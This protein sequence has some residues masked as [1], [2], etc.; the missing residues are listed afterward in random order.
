MGDHRASRNAWRVWAAAAG[1]LLAANA[2]SSL[3]GLDKSY[4]Q[5]GAGQGGAEQDA[6]AGADHSSTG[7]SGGSGRGGAAG[8]AGSGVG[9]TGGSGGVAGAAG[10]SGSSGAGGTVPECDAGTPVTVTSTYTPDTTLGASYDYSYNAIG[11]CPPYRWTIVQGAL[12]PGL[13][14]SL[15]GKITGASTTLGTYTFTVECCD[16]VG[17]C[18]LNQR[19]I[20]VRQPKG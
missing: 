9:S 17:Q 11:G 16:S 15:G 10:T 12:P 3:I 20:V 18:E 8:V 2:C 19:G 1:I 13:H 5:G 4:T 7:G 14:M 6:G